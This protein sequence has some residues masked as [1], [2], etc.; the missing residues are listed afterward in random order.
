MS[1][2]TVMV[3][4]MYIDLLESISSCLILLQ[5][6]TLKIKCVLVVLHVVVEDSDY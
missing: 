4:I 2:C 5:E 1:T 6:A 3:N